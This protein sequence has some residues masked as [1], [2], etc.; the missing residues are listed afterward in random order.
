MVSVKYVPTSEYLKSVVN[1]ASLQAE[2]LN[3]IE[4]I[5]KINIMQHAS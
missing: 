5:K 4:K 3:F 1:A 2:S